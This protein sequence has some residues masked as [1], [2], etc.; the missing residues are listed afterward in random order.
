MRKT[1]LHILITVCVGSILFASCTRR[2]YVPNNNVSQVED[3]NEVSNRNLNNAVETTSAKTEQLLIDTIIGFSQR[4]IGSPY[5]YGGTS[6]AGFDCSGYVQYVF[7]SNGIIIPRMPADMAAMSEKVNYSDIRPGDL[8]YFKGSDLNSSEIGHVALVTE[9]TND[10]F[11][12]IHSTTSK[13]VIISDINEYEYW[14]SRYLFATR[15]KRETLLA[16]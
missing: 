5:K 15:F 16:F 11:K 10:G 14:K 13:G 9:K 4:Y 6:P 8:V 1:S 3:N 2:M 12:F 7:K